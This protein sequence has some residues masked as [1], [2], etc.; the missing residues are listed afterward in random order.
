MQPSESNPDETPTSRSERPRNVATGQRN[1]WFIIVVLSIAVAYVIYQ[2]VDAKLGENAATS[3]AQDLAGP[4]DELCRT[5]PSARQ[6]IGNEKCGQAAEVQR[7]ST[8]AIVPRDG[9]DGSAGRDGK[10][11]LD[12]RGIA[13]TAVVAGHLFVTYT[14]GTREDKGVIAV[15]GQ[16]GRGITSARLDA[17]QLVL[18]YT[19][20]V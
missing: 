9:R 11:G 13:S 17:G 3:T 5:N 20:G 16:D 8:A 7:E 18:T 15:D 6:Q 2:Q 19:D 4:V 12:G 10:N 14:D 1:Q